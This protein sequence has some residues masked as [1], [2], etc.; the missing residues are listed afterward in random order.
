MNR[1][2]RLALHAGTVVCVVGLSKAH[3][4]VHVYSWSG[5][6]RFAWSL[7]YAFLLAVTAYAFGLPD[8]PRTRRAATLAAVG[9]TAIG[10]F[11]ISVLQLFVGDALLP[12]FVVLG[13]AVILVPWYLLCSFLARDARHVRPDAIG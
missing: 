7:G 9:A 5:S 6:S 1:L 8:Q 12:R 13:S 4:V 11:S 3:A 10:A 2:A